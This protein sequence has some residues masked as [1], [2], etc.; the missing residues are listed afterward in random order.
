MLTKLEY[1][2]PFTD[3]NFKNDLPASLADHVQAKQAGS[4]HMCV[5]FDSLN[6]LFCC[7]ACLFG[8]DVICQ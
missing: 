1:K 7:T 3:R 8:L 4:C 5:D 2:R 6:L